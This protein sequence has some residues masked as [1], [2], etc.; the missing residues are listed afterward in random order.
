MLRA[1]REVADAAATG[2]LEPRIG[3][4]GHDPDALAARTSVNGLLDVIDA[5][6]RDAVKD[7]GRATETVSS[8][9]STSDEIRRSVDLIT[10]MP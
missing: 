7:A 3:P 9:R 6:V 4:Q 10:Q 8:L 2:E 1:I 5:Y